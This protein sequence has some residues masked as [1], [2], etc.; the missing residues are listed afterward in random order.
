MMVSTVIANSSN[1]PNSKWDYGFHQAE[2][3]SFME[4]GIKFYIF[5]DGEMDFDIHANE[6]GTTTEYYYRSSRNKA[7]HTSHRGTKV[8][9]DYRGRVIRVGRVFINYNYRNQ[10]SRIG[11]VFIRYRRELMTKV[12]G[13]RIIY[14]RYG[15]VK[16]IGYVKHNYYSSYY[17]NYYHDYY[18][19]NYVYNY[20]DHFFNNDFFNDYEQIDEDDNYYY[21]RSKGKMTKRKNG[22]TES[23][24]KLIKRKKQKHSSNKA[25]KKQIRSHSR[26]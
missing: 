26:R 25:P 22:K 16:Y 8:V 10:I 19:D 24:Q 3:I 7:R 15:E 5:P 18:Y 4:R 14:N 9:R 12:G 1:R 17:S 20:N 23:K 2:P 11:S 6:G 13:L 21:Y